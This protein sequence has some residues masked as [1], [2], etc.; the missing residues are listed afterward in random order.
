MQSSRCRIIIVVMVYVLFDGMLSLFHPTGRR[1]FQRSLN[2]IF[3]TGVFGMDRCGMHAHPFGRADR[4]IR[5][6]KRNVIPG[7]DESWNLQYR[8]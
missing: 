2:P 7:D 6:T 4:L 1:E 5:R 8:T 3:I